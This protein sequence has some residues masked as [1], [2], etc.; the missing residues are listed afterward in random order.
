MAI[1]RDNYIVVQG[2]MVTD[3]HLKGTELLVYACI[4]G[5]SQSEGQVFT[6]SL[7][8]LIEWTNS[9]RRSVIYAL[10]S[11]V[12]KHLIRKTEIT[13][14]GVK[15]CEYAAVLDSAKIA[16]L[17]QNLHGGGAK[18]ARGGGAK[19]APAYTLKD[20]IDKDNIED[21]IVKA[22]AKRFTP[23]SVDQVAEYCKER[24]N[25][26]DAQ[27]FVDYYASNG[28]KVGRN[29][30]KDWKAAVRTWERNGI[31]NGKTYGPTGVAIQKTDDD[32]LAGI[33]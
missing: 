13:T 33:L 23:P 8:Y 16:P 25:G 27:R 29:A 11:L 17:V 9:S 26:V 18:I 14:N 15:T 32:D 19:S 22:P 10:Q 24:K 31:A 6:G 3:L 28:W 1:N 21:N 20:N 2:W 7:K 12:E 30:M 5:F 4:Y